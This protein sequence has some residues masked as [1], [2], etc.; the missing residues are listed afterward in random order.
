M[1][2][3]YRNALLANRELSIRNQIVA[4]T[5]RTGL[6][7]AVRENIAKGVYDRP[8]VIAATAHD[9]AKSGDVEPVGIAKIPVVPLDDMAVE[10]DEAFEGGRR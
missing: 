5:V 2:N 7:S 9:V 8:E 4:A 6:V 3:E 10:Y 1:S